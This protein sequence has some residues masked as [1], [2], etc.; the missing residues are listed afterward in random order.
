MPYKQV[1]VK[2]ERI[3]KHKGVSVFHTYK[4]DDIENPS[5]CWFTLDP[6]DTDR[7][8]RAAFDVRDLPQYAEVM[9]RMEPHGSLR[10]DP[11]LE[12]ARTILVAAIDAGGLK[13]GLEGEEFYVTDH[14][15]ILLL[16]RPRYVLEPPEGGPPV[17]VWPED[18][19]GFDDTADD[20][21]VSCRL[22]YHAYDPD[23]EEHR[24]EKMEQALEYVDGVATKIAALPGIREV[25]PER[26]P[27]RGVVEVKVIGDSIPDLLD[28]IRRVLSEGTAWTSGSKALDRAPWSG[29]TSKYRL[30]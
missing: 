8:G 4:E 16:A 24:E 29:P 7:E 6:D 11:T 28:T 12:E 13:P 30:D 10:V 22:D 15:G 21:T 9:A 25:L 27:E 14:D 2:P 20:D 1:Y 3:V 5:G 19:L 23:R 26:R 18:L 17:Q